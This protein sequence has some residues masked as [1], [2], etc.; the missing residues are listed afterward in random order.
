[1]KQD[2]AT[3]LTETVTTFEKLMV[4]FAKDNELEINRLML[5]VC[6]TIKEDIKRG[7]LEILE[8]ITV[9]ETGES[10]NRLRDVVGDKTNG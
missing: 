1:M 2:F 7:V 4:E 8:G 6:D 9:E 3:E 10:F 5:I